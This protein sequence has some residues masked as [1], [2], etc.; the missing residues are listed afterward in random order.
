MFTG[1]AGNQLSEIIN[2]NKI[3]FGSY[4]SGSGDSQI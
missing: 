1:N 4:T 3:Y 2:Q